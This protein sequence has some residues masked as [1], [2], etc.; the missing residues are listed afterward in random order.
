MKQLTVLSGKG[1]TGK[2]SFTAALARL[3]PRP[4]VADGDVDAPNLHLLLRARRDREPVREFVGGFGVEVEGGRCDGCGECVRVCRFDAVELVDAGHGQCAR[5]DP[6]ACEGCG[7]CAQVCPPGAITMTRRVAGTIHVSESDVGPLVHAHLR[8]AEEN[9]GK[10]VSQVRSI[11]AELARAEE[12]ELLLVDGPPGV[13]CPAIASL[14]GADAALLVT[15]P[16]A[17]GLADL[18]RVVS[19]VEHF[20]L[21]AAV[22]LNK[23][24]LYPP[25]EG[26][27]KELCADRRLR[28]LGGVPYDATF[29]RAARIGRTVVEVGS[30]P[31]VGRLLALWEDV[32]GFLATATKRRVA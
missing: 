22:L 8:V 9:S 20:R 32:A 3:A 7:F 31:L 17:A 28:Y 25:A 30:P 13:G 2:T 6:F 16:T 5:V 26:A 15:E 21:P 24:D 19:L 11:A 14:S 10:L 4:V 23:A 12:R 1:G 18:E 29:H 27:V